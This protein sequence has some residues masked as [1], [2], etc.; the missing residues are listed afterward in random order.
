MLNFR[1]KNPYRSDE[2]E[3]SDDENNFESN[4][5]FIFNSKGDEVIIPEFDH[6]KILAPKV[7]IWSRDLETNEI[8]KHFCDKILPNVQNISSLYVAF[9]L[10]ESAIYSLI[11]RRDVYNSKKTMIRESSFLGLDKSLNDN[12]NTPNDN[13]KN[14]RSREFVENENSKEKN[15]KDKNS[16]DN[17]NN[18]ANK[19]S[20]NN[21]NENI[22]K[23]IIDN[24]S[25][26]N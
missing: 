13:S 8:E 7:K 1:F 16:I 3:I 2:E 18:E 5:N 20:E 26:I 11:K 12:N 22:L 9:F 19:K 6:R 15:R 17:H 14:F 21:L 24:E 4:S 10:F 25:K 23:N